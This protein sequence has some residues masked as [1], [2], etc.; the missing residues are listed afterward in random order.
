VKIQ[1]DGPRR[2]HNPKVEVR[3]ATG[4]RILLAITR[5]SSDTKHPTP[6]EV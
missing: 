6:A 2:S 5:Y 1:L 3:L 4:D